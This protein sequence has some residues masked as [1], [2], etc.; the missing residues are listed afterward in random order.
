MVGVRGHRETGPCVV[1]ARLRVRV[2]RIY[3]RPWV[4]F[5]DLTVPKVRFL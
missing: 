3:A 4:M 1:V 2:L 5:T